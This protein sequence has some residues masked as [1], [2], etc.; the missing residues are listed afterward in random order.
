MRVGEVERLGAGAGAAEIVHE[1]NWNHV[2]QR[3]SR[4]MINSWQRRW[5]LRGNQV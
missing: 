2:P 5:G 3:S 1:E 4:N